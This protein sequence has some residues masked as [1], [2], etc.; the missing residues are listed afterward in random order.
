MCASTELPGHVL[1]YGSVFQNH[2]LKRRWHSLHPSPPRL[3]STLAR[4]AL[5]L[6]HDSAVILAPQEQDILSSEETSGPAGPKK[7]TEASGA[8]WA[9]EP[10]CLEREHQ[11]QSRADCS[12][13]SS[14]GAPG[15]WD[16]PGATRLGPAP[17]PRPVPSRWPPFPGP[18]AA[19]ST[20]HGPPSAHHSRGPPNGGAAGR[21]GGAGRGLRQPAAGLVASMR[22]C[23]HGE[24]LRHLSCGPRHQGAGPARMSASLVRATVRAVS[25]R[26]LQATRAALTLVSFRARGLARDIGSPPLRAGRPGRRGAP[27]PGGGASACSAALCLPPLGPRP[28][29]ENRPGR[30]CSAGAGAPRYYVSHRAARRLGG[31][32]GVRA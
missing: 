31:R 21:G 3:S 22:R 14:G 26:K 2:H 1:G 29:W 27:Q 19:E 9:S 5:Y 30:G 7:K 11:L 6:S 10:S 17:T 32:G 24:R 18:C 4:G 20:A 28:C 12:A 16:A 15:P 23:V 13:A 8:V 25:K